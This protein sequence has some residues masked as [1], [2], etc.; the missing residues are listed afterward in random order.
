MGTGS[1]IEVKRTSEAV[2]VTSTLTNNTAK[3]VHAAP[4]AKSHRVITAATIQQADTSPAVST[5]QLLSGTTVKWQFRLIDTDGDGDSINFDPPIAM[6]T[7]EAVYIDQSAASNTV[8]YSVASE[9]R[10]D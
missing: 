8:L 1:G 2:A 7:A 6:D 5:V 4:P 9:I 10:P 3:A